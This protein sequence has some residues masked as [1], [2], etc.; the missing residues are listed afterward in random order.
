MLDGNDEC[1]GEGIGAA[2]AQLLPVNGALEHDEKSGNVVQWAGADSGAR[3]WYCNC[4]KGS[5]VSGVDGG[6]AILICIG[7][8]V[9]KS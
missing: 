1:S 7:C 8:V 2:S 3:F 9:G 6:D 5:A 4:E